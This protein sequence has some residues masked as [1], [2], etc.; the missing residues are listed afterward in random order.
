MNDI[1]CAITSVLQLWPEG[2]FRSFRLSA[3]GKESGTLSRLRS[4]I[5]KLSSLPE[6]AEN[7]DLSLRL[8]RIP[9]TIGWE[10]H[11]RSSPRPLSL[12]AWK[13]YAFPGSLDPTLA[14]AMAYLLAEVDGDVLDP[15]CG[16]ATLLIEMAR[17]GKSRTAL[18]GFDSHEDHICGAMRNV[19]EAGV[20]D[21]IVLSSSSVD[22]LP[23]SD[24]SISAVI[25]N[26]PW[27]ERVGRRA[28][29][30][31]RYAD[32]FKEMRRVLRPKAKLVLLTQ[33][34][35]ALRKA[36][37][38]GFRIQSSSKVSQ[39]GFHPELFQLIS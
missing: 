24:R 35:N 10:F 33:D 6:D 27:G 8:R 25:S 16:S 31:K 21:R 12:R 34:S 5:V 4:E 20:E 23:L 2:S 28:E 14:A 18:L 19:K 32:F 11:V 7:G 1:A 26:L 13:K 22:D 3:A 37:P 36:L 29:N 39:G 9:D 17:M 38:K 15:F 30:S